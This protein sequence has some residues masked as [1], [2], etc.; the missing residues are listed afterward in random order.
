MPERFSPVMRNV[1]DSLKRGLKRHIGATDDQLA[2]LEEA[3]AQNIPETIE[4]VMGACAEGMPAPE[5]PKPPKPPKPLKPL[6]PLKPPEPPEP[7]KK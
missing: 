4:H 2:E 6:N 5:R 1:L 3:F 7:P